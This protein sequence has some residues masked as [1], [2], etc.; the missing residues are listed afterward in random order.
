MKLIKK[1]IEKVTAKIDKNIVSP[2]QLVFLDS[3]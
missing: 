3:L 1:M 2:S